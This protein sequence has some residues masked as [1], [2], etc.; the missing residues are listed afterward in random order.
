MLSTALIACLV[1]TAAGI[2]ALTHSQLMPSNLQPKVDQALALHHHGSVPKLSAATAV[3]LLR[4][5]EAGGSG[6]VEA[7]ANKAA[8]DGCVTPRPGKLCL[9]VFLLLYCLC[10]LIFVLL[11][12]EWTGCCTGHATHDDASGSVELCGTVHHFHHALS[13]QIYVLVVLSHASASL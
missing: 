13:R 1:R 9:L 7:A 3:A 11:V 2:P 6:A 12:S 8:T 10:F 4:A 5:S